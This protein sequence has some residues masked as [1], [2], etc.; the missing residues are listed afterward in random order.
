MLPFRGSFRSAV[1]AGEKTGKIAERV[2]DLKVPYAGEFER[3]TKKATAL[4]MLVVMAGLLPFF[5][6]SMYTSLVAPMIALMEYS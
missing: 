3:I 2:E 5:I 6:I 4:L 1:E